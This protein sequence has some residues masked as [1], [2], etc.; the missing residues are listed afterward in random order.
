MSLFSA[1]VLALAAFA[2]FTNALPADE[3][4]SARA[5]GDGDW[6]AAY[7]KATTALAKLSQQ[8]KVN[9]VTGQGWMKGPCVGTTAAVSSIGYPQLCLQDGPLGVRF[10]QGV[11][12]FPAGI[13]AAATWDIDLIKARGN[14]LGRLFCIKP[15]DND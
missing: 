7:S 5:S 11:T 3:P 8:D 9:M 15:Y 4:L 1:A 2:P 12:A 14:A 13:H 10:A 6:A